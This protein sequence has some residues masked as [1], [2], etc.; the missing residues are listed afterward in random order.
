MLELIFG[1]VIFMENLTPKQQLIYDFIKSEIRHRGITPSIREIGNA[2]GLSSTSSVHAQLETLERKGYILRSKSK[3]RCIEILE[4]NFYSDSA[5]D[6]EY[7]SIPIVGTV[8]AGMPILAEENLEGYFPVPVN[9]LQNNETFMLRVRGNS[10][11]N[12]GILNNDLVLVN[13]QNT[14]EN[15][16]IVIALLDDS[17]TCKRFY[18]EK[19][20]IRLQP[21]NDDYQPIIVRDIKILGKV[22]G[23]FRTFK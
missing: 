2:S 12:C 17:A 21:E 22:I 7:S 11:I 5:L 20:F 8:T 1:K 19:D 9:Y 3:N 4:D 15:G 10:M 16:E 6:I 14:A 18:R 13:Q 23:L